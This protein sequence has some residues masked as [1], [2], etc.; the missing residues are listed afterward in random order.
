MIMSLPR[1]RS[2][3]L[4]RFLTYGEWVCGHEE[5]RHLRTLDDVTTW[6]SQGCTGTAETAA[7]PFWR[8][9][10]E[11][12]RIVLVR[13]PVGQVVD[14][15]LALPGLTFDRAGLEVL[16]E[17]HD[18]KLDQIAT[19]RDV[20]S[21]NFDDLADEATCAKVF[22]YCLP[23]GHDPEHWARLAPINVQCHMVGLMRYAAA[24]GPALEKLGKVARHT[25]LTRLAVKEPVSVDGMVLGTE[26]FDTW[27]KDA[28]HLF[29]E[30]LIR[31]GEAPGDW[32]RKNI[33][34]MR[35]L[36]EAGAMQITTARSN[37]RMFGYLMTLISPSLTSESLTSG[38]NTTFYASPDVP[39][40]GLKLQRAALKALK[41]RGIGE[42]FYE[43]GQRGDGPRLGTMYRR[44]GATEHG[45][46][47]RL[48]LTE[49]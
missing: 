14:S 9:I 34:L 40:L 47:Y 41:D 31:V 30:H 11:N 12:V 7:A 42:V 10:P 21:V 38:S 25:I 4:A 29:D 23:Y 18:R 44:L 46:V 32:E 48:E 22:E 17:R 49:H 19:R 16:M 33:P 26:D 8:L 36:Y 27:L 20:L 37:G 15:L 3:W 2:A 13:R 39:G 45:Q 43:A 5:L 35:R 6:F 1:S 28:G 24:F